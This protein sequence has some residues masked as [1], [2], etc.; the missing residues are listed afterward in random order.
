MGPWQM[1]KDNLSSFY[2]SSL[3]LPFPPSLSLFWG[4]RHMYV[5]V[6]AGLVSSIPLKN[7]EK[8]KEGGTVFATKF[9]RLCVSCHQEGNCWRLLL[10]LWKQ[11]GTWKCLEDLNRYKLL[12]ILFGMYQDFTGGEIKNVIHWIKKEL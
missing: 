5:G 4:E 7:T 1:R 10:Y 8:E 12:S 2:L 6:C 9:Q 3:P 11:N